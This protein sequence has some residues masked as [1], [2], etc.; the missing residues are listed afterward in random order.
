MEYLFVA[1]F[2]HYQKLLNSFLKERQIGLIWARLERRAMLVPL[3]YFVEASVQGHPFVH[4]YCCP[5]Q[6][7]FLPN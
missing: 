2:H 7:P 5:M 6:I 4:F 3:C 1:M